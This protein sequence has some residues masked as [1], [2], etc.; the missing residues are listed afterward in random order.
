M[1]KI[2]SYFLTEESKKMIREFI[3]NIKKIIINRIEEHSEIEEEATLQV[4]ILILVTISVL[5]NVSYAVFFKIEFQNLFSKKNFEIVIELFK[6]NMFIFVLRYISDKSLFKKVYNDSD[7]L[8]KQIKNIIKIIVAFI[9]F[10]ILFYIILNFIISKYYPKDDILSYENLYS[11]IYLPIK[12][13]GLLIKW[14]WEKI[15]SRSLISFIIIFF[16]FQIN[17][18]IF[19]IV[20]KFI[21]KIKEFE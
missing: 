14:I 8:N 17:H 5:M 2:F 6:S 19:L 9:V 3:L 12:G 4:L 18:F 13:L 15:L 21:K 11:L 10:F 7:E 20:L 16:I 1:K